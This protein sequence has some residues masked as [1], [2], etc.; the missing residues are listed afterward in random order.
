MKKQIAV[1][2]ALF[3]IVITARPVLADGII[4]IDPP[5]DPPPDWQPW[6]TIRYHRVTVAIED[7]VAVT[8]VD[9]AF[10]NDGKVPAEG[11]YVFPLPPGAVVQSFVMWVDGKPIEGEILPADKARDIY[12]S[13]V[14]RQRD[15]ALLEYVGRDAVRARIFPIPA[16][17]ERRIQLE[18]TQVLP[19]A[20]DMMAYRY[21]LN[22]ERFSALPL[23]QVSISVSLTS[24]TPLRAIYSPSHQ[25]EV[26]ITRE[27]AHRA[28]ISYEANHVLPERDFELYVGTGS[29]DIGVNLLTYQTGDEDGF[30]LL[31]LMP[32]LATEG[33]RILPKDIFLVLD[34]S[35]SMEGDKLK[36][37]QDALVY[38]L[39]HLNPEDRFN[40]IAFSSGVRMYA[41]TLQA[42]QEAD[43]AS[44]WV[45]R[46]EALG[47]TNIYLALSAALAQANATRPT[48]IIFLTDGLATEGIVEAQTL[49]STLAQEAPPSVRIFPFGVGYDVNTL[50]LDQ[51][52]Q[53][54]KGIPAYVKP[55]ERIAEN[56][57]AFY[58]RIQ[59]PV[60][61]NVTLE[62]GAI[63]TYDV[64]PTPLPDLY[65]GTQLIVTGRYTGSGPQSITL[66]GEVEG[67]RATYEY[68]GNFQADK[69]KDFIPR[70]WAARKIGYLLTQIRLHG[71]NA[72]WI[73]A[74]VDLSRRYG[75]ITPYTSFLVEEPTDALSTEGREHAAEEFTESLQA[76]PT[77]VSGASAVE[78][79]EMRKGLGNAE[80]PPAAGEMLSSPTGNDA[81]KELSSI[82]YVGDKTFLCQNGVCIDTAYIP[83]QMTPQEV[84]FMSAMYWE[85]TETQP[86]LA[87]YFAVG[88][89]V[90]CVADD[91][92]AYH[93]RLGA[94]AEE[95]ARPEASSTEEASP[96]P[97]PL[98]DTD[99]PQPAA[100]GHS[101]ICGSAAA[102]AASAAVVGWRGK[103][104]F[105]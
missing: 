61:T 35:G 105:K 37:A 88:E 1:L 51:L 71:E 45:Y 70:L 99:G 22:T 2:L 57:S 30:F 33:Q 15:P 78:D 38:V 66:T 55:E 73:D 29:E 58:A 69:S 43:A 9:Q 18:Y 10:R 65:A 91:G 102:L 23:E 95:I 20:D 76:A 74:V 28:T 100:R 21:P 46:L 93:F 19:I 89:E 11:T 104:R 48:V 26:V 13:Y 64:Y 40:V 36:Q 7:Q 68:E 75:I 5:V 63:R 96:T 67:Q 59:S 49:L 62:C 97:T 54:H 101:G 47:G 82:R 80:A 79:A 44:D 77:A 90:F 32:A 31:T 83:D 85:L 42:G 86:E 98:P 16:G 53:D 17:E 14:Q 94:E 56:V 103:R 4:I 25:D 34:T 8:K 81:V 84:P 6:L 12:E 52:A 39:E 50:F 27:G 72:E 24:K 3:V 60:L 41:T 92:T 87:A